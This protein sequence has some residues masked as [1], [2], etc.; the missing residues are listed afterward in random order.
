MSTK[1]NQTVPGG[2]KTPTKP[3]CDPFM[4]QSSKDGMAFVFVMSGE[5]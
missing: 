4:S 5:R 2:I 1:G 3:L